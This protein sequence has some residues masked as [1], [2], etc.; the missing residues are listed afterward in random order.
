MRFIKL[1]IISA[2]VLFII[3]TLIS[4]LLPPNVLVSR[5]V[6]VRTSSQKAKEKVFNLGNWKEWMAD[7]SGTNATITQKNNSINIAGT[8][9]TPQSTTGSTFTT[10]W[11]SDNNKLLSTFHIIIHPN[12]DSLI[13]IQWQMEQKVKW[14]PWEKF[15]SITKDEIWGGAMEKSLDNLKKLL[16]NN[17]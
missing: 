1:A 12:A 7:A 10:Y 11:L 6:D 5:A 4:L 8:E 13:T 16:E 2:I 17:N 3:I 15:A 14:Y 9:I